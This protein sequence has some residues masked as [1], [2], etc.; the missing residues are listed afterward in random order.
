MSSSVVNSW[1]KCATVILI[2]TISLCFQFLTTLTKETYIHGSIVELA[3][4][5]DEN[6]SCKTEFRGKWHFDNEEPSYGFQ[7]GPTNT[8]DFDDR[9]VGR[10]NNLGENWSFHADN[11][12]CSQEPFN[13][14]EW[15]DMVKHKQLCFFGDSLSANMADTLQNELKRHPINGTS[16]RLFRE[17]TMFRHEGEGM[18]RKNWTVYFSEYPELKTCDVL[19]LNT[20]LFWQAKCLGK[21]VGHDEFAK[22][23]TDQ[24]YET[25]MELKLYNAAMERIFAEM[26]LNK[27]GLKPQAQVF[28]RNYPVSETLLSVSENNAMLARLNKKYPKVNILNVTAM[29]DDTE[30]VD[31]MRVCHC[32]GKNPNGKCD[33]L[34]FC[35][36]GSVPK[37][38]TM[39]LVRHMKL[40]Q[41]QT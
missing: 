12:L 35:L 29:M 9:Y 3:S 18:Y 1:W 11:E 31:A 21:V 7:H 23:T 26:H 4:Q 5:Q 6:I 2:V 40:L 28:W 15:K 25:G 8:S 36:G 38:W 24:L 10:V 20:A 17:Y 33:M 14:N 37:S 22:K 32:K 16:V 13:F 27:V 41:G 34:H 30:S 39:A 19:V